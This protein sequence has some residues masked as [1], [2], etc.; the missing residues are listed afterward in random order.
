MRRENG[1]AC[2]VGNM[3]CGQNSDAAAYPTVIARA[4]DPVRRGL[5][6][7]HGCLWNTGS[8]AFAEDDSQYVE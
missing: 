5:S 4:G 2:L 6:V 1:K 3:S 7:K 8:S